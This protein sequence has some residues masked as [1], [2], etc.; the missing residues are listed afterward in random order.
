MKLAQALVSKKYFMKE[1]YNECQVACDLL[2]KQIS[3]ETNENL[4]KQLVSEKLD[5]FKLIKDDVIDFNREIMD[6]L[7]TGEA[8][9]D[10]ITQYYF[11]FPGKH[12]RPTIMLTLSRALQG[13]SELDFKE[14][15]PLRGQMVFAQVIEMI[16][17][18]SLIHDDVIDKGET[19]RGQEAIHRKVGNKTAVM[20]GN[21][22]ISTASYV[23]TLLDDMRLMNLISEIMENLSKGELIQA[24]GACES[25]EEHV[26][27]YCH[28]TY[29][30]TAS[31]IAHGCKG[32]GYFSG[33]P[34]EC[35]EFGK[36]LGLGFQYID[37]IL[38]FTGDKK[39]LGKPNLNDMKEGLA[40]GPVLY[41]I[42]HDP[43]LLEVVQ[44]KFKESGDI[45]HGQQAALQYGI[46]ITRNLAL[47]HLDMALK[48]LHFIPKDSFAF[49][50]LGSLSA[51]IYDRIS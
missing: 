51:K 7:Y 43:S 20:G 15:K 11:K 45:E 22:L 31:L 9:I 47:Y 30:K 21:Y 50:A 40:T 37:D 26:I 32:I 46:E 12:F 29:F 44:R 49:N 34:D 13:S 48:S 28:K 23:C 42:P 2:G 10:N 17:C 39:T 4:F 19:R 1:L 5:P 24:E 38:D 18:S 16:H 6:N 33:Y 25:L 3:K 41:S 35:F 14:H 36:H 27:S 8:E